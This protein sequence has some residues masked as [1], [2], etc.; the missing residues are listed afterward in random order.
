MNFQYNE[1]GF[2]HGSPVE[3]N[4]M[5]AP[6]TPALPFIRD[7]IEQTVPARFERVARHFP[8]HIALTGDGRRWTYR[9]LNVRVNRIA[10]A[11]RE[12]TR[13]GVGCV[14]YLLDHSPEMVIAT[15]AVL[16]AGKTYLA[17]HPGTPA[18]AQEE[19]VREVSPELILTMDVHEARAKALAGPANTVL[20]LSAID[21][22]WP[23]EDPPASADPRAHSTIFYTSGSTGQSK[24]VVKSHRAVLHRVWLSAQHDVITP[25]DRQSLLTHC[26]FSASESDIFGALLQGA[27]LHTFDIASKGFAA[28]RIWLEELQITL[29]HPPA[30][31]FRRFLSTLEGENLFPS[32]RLVAL[33]GDVVL[34]SDLKSWRRHFSKSC[35][36]LH[37]FSITETALLTVGRVD[38]ETILD[39]D[40]VSA[41][42]PVSD[43]NLIVIDD[44]GKTV[45][46]GETGELVVRSR[47]LAEGYWHRPDE[48]ASVF[49]ADPE[50]PGQRI[51]RTGDLGYFRPDGSFVFM[52]RRDH[53]LKIRGYRVDTREIESTLL[54]L[55]E[56]REATTVVQN[57]NGEKRIL[58]FVA[59]KEGHPFDE[60]SL[61]TSL[62]TYLPDWKIPARFHPISVL[63]ITLTG[64][65]DRKSLEREASGVAVQGSV[66]GISSTPP[67]R[68]LEEELAEI[69]RVALKL[70]SVGYDDSFLQ[71]GGDSISTMTALEQVERRYGIR[72]SPAEFYQGSSIRQIVERIR[73]P[74]APPDQSAVES[75]GKIRQTIRQF[76]DRVGGRIS[77]DPR[78]ADNVPVPQAVP[79][80]FIPSETELKIRGS[81][82]DANVVENVSDAFVELL[83]S[84]AVDYI[85]INP[86]SDSAPI[87]ESIA[88]F[89]DLGHRTPE[90]VLCLHESV[91]L[92]AAHGYFMVSGRPQIVFVHVDVGTLNLGANLHNAQRGRAGVVICA[93]RTPYT[94]EGDLPGGR[95]RRMHWMQEQFN[96]SGIVQGY[97][98]WHYELSRADNLWVAGQRAFQIAGTEPAGPVYLTFPREVLLD[99]APTPSLN[100]GNPGTISSPAADPNSLSQA[101]QWL[102]EAR[103]P[104]VLV[105]YSGRNPNA[106][107]ALVRLA[108][109]L[110]VPV[111]ET[112]YRVNF[113]STHPLHLG[114][115]LSPALEKADCIL[116]IDHDVPWVPA[117]MRPQT[118]C[119]TIHIDSDPLKRDIP[120]WGF[121]VDLAIHADSVQAMTA[122]NEEVTRRITPADRMR[123]ETRRRSVGVEHHAQ[124]ARWSQRAHSLSSRRPIAPEWAAFCLNEIVD[125]NTL[126]VG[127]AASNTLVLWNYLQ[128]DS[129]GS[130]YE[131]LGSGLGWGLGAALGAKMAAP[132]KTVICVLG[133]GAWMFATPIASYWASQQNKSPFLTVIFNNEEYYSTTEAILT[134]APAGYAKKNGTYPACDL[135]EAGMY[136]RVA[137]SIGLWA[138]TVED[139][140]SLPAVLREGLDQVRRGRSAL[141]NIRVSSP[142]PRESVSLK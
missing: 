17:I 89:K 124:T 41:G 119:R 99:K 65:V 24:A 46:Q 118:S 75:P 84:L 85:F 6:T 63:P 122:L 21:E 26:S 141:V 11:I 23:D 64:K 82:P 69:W 83:N 102:I 77:T 121:S 34:P 67:P 13:P 109:T 91:A 88:K 140:A 47:Y 108:E 107:S 31:L 113:P 51:Y 137:E 25:S 62:R 16:K 71:L 12:R 139:P 123:I 125:E 53:Q 78:P 22:R 112:R 20:L 129:P 37:R 33:A 106:V 104:L 132:A 58:A 100:P 101:A 111:V 50:V 126:I 92:A 30:L 72:I 76:M 49:K 8:G 3:Q 55:P 133:D 54:Q 134:T 29:L 9:E 114:Y 2:P 66:S 117:Q 4:E 52:G 43:K 32:V 81:E 42:H 103:S 18:A 116:I 7:D 15:L 70:E 105:S 135:P 97:V 27:S 1:R 136:T 39:A 45:P 28:F 44:T 14:A 110:G 40:I 96:Q 115:S 5:T 86:G 59:L 35:V 128:L 73:T 74:A 87:L 95:N 130:Y 60:S 127:E 138:R 93:G 61:R 90:L 94:V 10:H 48:T 98:K 57:E 38:S 142:R 80:K 19:V 56:V 79:V 131:S 68:S 120:I 36:L